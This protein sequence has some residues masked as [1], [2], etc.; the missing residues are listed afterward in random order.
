MP[1][2]LY[3]G[4]VLTVPD[5]LWPIFRANRHLLR[6]LP[7]L[8]AGVIQHWVYAEYGVKLMMTVMPHTFG[9]HLNFNPHLHVLA[10]AAVLHTTNRWVPTVRFDERLAECNHH[11]SSPSLEVASPQNQNEREGD[12]C[13]AMATI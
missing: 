1:D 8:G 5:I 4:I 3:A 9:R 6:D 13:Y 10:S 12:T 2:I 11:L 7:A